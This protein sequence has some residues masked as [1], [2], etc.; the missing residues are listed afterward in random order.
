MVKNNI[1]YFHRTH[2]TLAERTHILGVVQG[3]IDLGHNVYVVS[4]WGVDIWDQGK[5]KSSKFLP[6]LWK[7]I[8]KYS[9]QILF[10]IFEIL[11]NLDAY[12]RLHRIIK[13]K[14]IDFIYSRYAVNMFI[15]VYLSKKYGIPI[16]LEVNDSANVDRARN[17]ILKGLSRKIE[18]YVFSGAD[19]IITVSGT[20]KKHIVWQGICEGKISVIQNAADTTLF[21]PIF[22]GREIREK[23]NLCNKIVLGYCG[24]FPK[25]HR[26]DVM[27]NLIRSLKDNGFNVAGFFV[28]DGSMRKDIE[29]LIQNLDLSYDIVLAGVVPYRNLNKYIS[30]MDITVLVSCGDYCSPVKI[31]EYMS[32]QKAVVAPSI[33][34]IKEVISNNYNGVLFVPDDEISLRDGLVRLIKDKNFRDDLGI[35]ARKTI[36]EKHTWNKNVKKILEIYNTLGR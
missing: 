22:S 21:D 31:F 35:N 17:S 16:L 36:V 32:M 15:D 18:R 30:A 27:C 28:G 29:L 33:E 7:F 2:S 8:S 5:D 9:P 10:E 19:K 14:K 4:P 23:Y 20:F 12:F 3:L 6:K 25:W 24:S 26:L 34:S 11:Y 13:T 1:I